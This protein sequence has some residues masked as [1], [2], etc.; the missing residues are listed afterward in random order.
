MPAHFTHFYTA[1]RVAEYLNSGNVPDWPGGVRGSLAKYR[2]QDL[3][4]FMTDWPKFTSI[5]AEGP[6][7]FYLSQDYNSNPLGPVSDEI[8][9]ALAVYYFYDYAK[10][11]NW[12][13]LL[14]ILAD[15]N[16]TLASLVRFLILLDKIWKDFIAVWNET[17][18]PFV[19]AA[20]SLLDDLTGGVVSEFGV[21]LGQLKE[22][23]ISIGKEELLTF[24]DILSTFNTCVHKG[25]DEQ[26]FLWSD[27]SHYR[28]TTR[29]ARALIEQAESLRTTEQGGGDQFQQFMAFAMGWIT[30]IGL[31]TIGHSFVNEQCGGP[32]R[33]H[34]QRHHLIEAHIDAWLYR[35]AGP[36]G[37]ITTDPIGATHTYQDLSYSGLWFAVQTTPDTPNGQDR[38][39]TLP[40]DPVQAKAVLDVDGQM[41]IWMAEAIDKALFQTFGDASPRQDDPVARPWTHPRI[42]Q[43]SSFQRSID[44]GLLTKIV[45]TVTGHGLDRPFS[46][47]LNDIA[48]APSFEVP[49]GFPLPW[50][51]QTMYRLLITFF[52]L[53]Y[54]G[55]WEL[56]K[57]RRPDVII[58]PPSSDITNLFSP[59]DFS[60]PSSGNPIE[61]ICD[62]LKSLFDW[63]TKEVDAALKLAGD[64]V[65][66]LA[67]PGSYPIRL[68]LYELAMLGWDIVS[69]THEIMAHTGF[70]IPHGEQH[71]DDNGELRLGNEIDLPLISLGG[72]V[73][74]SF[75][76]ALAD[77]VDPFGN[78][79]RDPSLAVGHDVKDV[80]YPYLTVMQF[81]AQT[82]RPVPN[83]PGTILGTVGAAKDVEFKR[84]WAYPNQSPDDAGHLQP[85]QTEVYD[86]TQPASENPPPTTRNPLPGPFPIGS[87][88]DQVFFR[89]NRLVDATVRAAYEN[90]RTPAETD[91]LNENHLLPDGEDGGSPLGDPVPFTAYLI[92]QLSNSNSYKTQFN[93]DSDRAYGYLTW[94]WIRNLQV[95]EVQSDMGF[96][97]PPPME[98]PQ[99]SK[100]WSGLAGPPTKLKL[101]YV[102]KP[103]QPPG[104]PLAGIG[105]ITRA[106]ARR[107]SARLTKAS[108][109]APARRKSAR[110]T[111]AST[112]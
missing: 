90:S 70:Y 19:N 76:Q 60:G 46:E 82:G 106:P 11:D 34:P 3:G 95:P 92:G 12:E 93:L 10:D 52:K 68:A 51:V 58:T 28:R 98:W 74:A 110:L 40:D 33:D 104:N 47:L 107:K 73:D 38:P 27:N 35:Q 65:K 13:P 83:P 6:D 102:D 99:G 80:K 15:Y 21:A 57:P 103:G 59:P 7:L 87:L 49:E 23:L 111:K 22:A 31:D 25:W 88:P 63:I 91:F 9:L 56:Y 61:D 14:Q 89:T 5:G 32:F 69:K 44:E 39:P 81:S 96:T 36:G 78:L 79:D 108:T 37:T 101:E 53:S 54:S 30:H 43:G 66:M 20:N 1:R 77:A 71:Y 105:P 8:M 62:A 2:P 17:I 86:P 112:R 16:S 67:S 45:E 26:N 42:Y 97:F 85:T 72:S 48:P 18:G 41:P 84:P 109:R 29:L 50:Q 24:G 100:L 4:K 64:I 55:D 94:D 75:Q